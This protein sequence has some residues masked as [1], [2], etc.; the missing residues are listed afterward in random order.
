VN[1]NE[2]LT[3]Q[4]DVLVEVV[5]PDGS[6]ASETRVSLSPRQRYVALIPEGV[7]IGYVRLTSNLPVQVMGTIG[8]RDGAVLDQIPA[9]K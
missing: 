7:G 6:V 9:V 1:P 2:M 5:R 4:T 8:S 3:V